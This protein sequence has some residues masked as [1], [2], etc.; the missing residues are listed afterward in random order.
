MSSAAVQSDAGKKRKLGDDNGDAGFWRRSITALKEGLWNP[1]RTTKDNADKAAA[2]AF[3][4]LSGKPLDVR[5]QNLPEDLPETQLVY[6]QAVLTKVHNAVQL[7]TEKKYPVHR[8]HYQSAAEVLDM[9]SGVYSLKVEF[10]DEANSKDFP[11]V[12]TRQL[13][14]A[15]GLGADVNVD[16][17]AITATDRGEGGY[18]RKLYV[19]V[20]FHPW[21]AE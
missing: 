15:S 17:I 19:Q 11:V 2:E 9:L 12:S 4:E 13:W 18:N 10:V 21:K 1:K 6:I 5:I 8:V 7:S 3:S 14:L 20:T 16:D